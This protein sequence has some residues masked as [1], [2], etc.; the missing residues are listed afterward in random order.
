MLRS[1]S[2]LVVAATA[3]A[4]LSCAGPAPREPVSAAEEQA[5]A[6]QIRSGQVGD[7]GGGK[8]EDAKEEKQMAREKKGFVQNIEAL[9]EDNR[10]FRRV[11]YTAEHCQLVV[12]ALPAGEHIGAEVHDVDQFFRVEEGTGEVVLGQTRTPIASGTAIVIPAG[13]KHDII[14]TGRKP[15]QLYTI[16]SPPH[17]RDGVLHRTR[18][19]GEKDEEHFEGTTTE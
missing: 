10:D 13:T 14:N 1:I 15:L 11:L 6:G 7:R 3:L 4:G 2:R 8:R 12:M 9:A 18:A 19:D 16:Y 5:R 17:H